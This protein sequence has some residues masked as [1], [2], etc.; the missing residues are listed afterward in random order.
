M[1]SAR[2][3]SIRTSPPAVGNPS[4]QDVPVLDNVAAAVY[5]HKVRDAFR[6]LGFVWAILN[7]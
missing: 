1:A 5:K 2:P 6:T 7:A 4:S 3:P